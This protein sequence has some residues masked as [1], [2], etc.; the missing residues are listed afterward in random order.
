MV[1]AAD[2]AVSGGCEEDIVVIM[3]SVTAFVVFREAVATVVNCTC[4][5]DGVLETLPSPGIDDDVE[6]PASG[7]GLL[8]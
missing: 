6:L 1:E 2:A 5:D 3:P 8:P 4:S 7:M